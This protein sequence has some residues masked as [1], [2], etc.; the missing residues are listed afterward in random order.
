MTL[1]N[2]DIVI[3]MSSAIAVVA[4]IAL[5]NTREIK[6][7]KDWIGGHPNSNRNRGIEGDVDSLRDKL[8]RIEQTQLTHH[9]E[10]HHKLDA[11]RRQLRGTCRTLVEAIDCQIDEA[12]L[13]ADEIV[14]DGREGD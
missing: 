5:R 6:R 8:D 3:A 11:Q 2:P 10:L 12:D 1:D 13:D 7:V 9:D 4:L 14:I